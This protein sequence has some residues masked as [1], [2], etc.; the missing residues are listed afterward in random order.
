MWQKPKAPD[1]EPRL[2]AILDED[3]PRFSEAEMARRHA[4]MA[5]LME[6]AEV[7]HLLL[8]GAGWFGASI[9]WLTGWPVT[10][11]AIGRSDVEID[12]QTMAPGSGTDPSPVDTVRT[13]TGGQWHDTALYQRDLLH[14]GQTV[15]GPAII[16]EATATTAIEPGWRGELNTRGHLV[17]ERHI[18]HQRHHAV[19]LAEPLLDL[20]EHVPHRVGVGDVGARDHHLGTAGLQRT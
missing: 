4:A 9:P 15:T 11:E 17:L 2:R 5:G 20:F 7:G 16:V 8:C 19:Q 14:P 3:F 13:Y 1:I 6:E 18:A 12:P 10:V